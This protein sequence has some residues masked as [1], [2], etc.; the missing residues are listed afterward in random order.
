MTRSRLSNQK[1]SKIAETKADK[2]ENKSHELIKKK[3]GCHRNNGKEK[4]RKLSFGL[5]DQT[6]ESQNPY[7]GNGKAEMEQFAET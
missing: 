5:I 6:L 3:Q 1:T 7:T 4:R 2:S